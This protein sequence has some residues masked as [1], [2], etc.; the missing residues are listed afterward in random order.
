MTCPRCKQENPPQAKFCLE[1]AAPLRLLP[2]S[3]GEAPDL[4]QRLA[5]AL[6]REAEA[7]EQQAATTDILRVISGSPSDVQPVFDTI[8]ATALR[9]CEARLC[10][11]FT[12]DGTLIHLVAS[13]HVSTDGAAAHRAAHPARPGRGGGTHRAILTG[14]IVGTGLGLALSRKFV[15]LH[16]GRIWAK[17]EVGAGSTFTFRLPVRHGE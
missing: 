12:F 10:T 11:V 7:R 4:A 5:E 8:A 3:D 16:G 2:K 17:S 1:C 9:L 15:E 13:H 6:R 14:Q